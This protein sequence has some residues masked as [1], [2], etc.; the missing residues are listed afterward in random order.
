M[1]MYFIQV[2]TRYGEA[3][4]WVA[5]DYLGPVYWTLSVCVSIVSR[6]AL[7]TGLRS[8][9]VLISRPRNQ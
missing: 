1:Y 3:E 6:L 9:R 4:V 7:V 2:V 5:H 8:E